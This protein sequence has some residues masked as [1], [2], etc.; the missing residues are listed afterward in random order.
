M[1]TVALCTTAKQWKQPKSP[2][3]NEWIKKTYLYTME[4]YSAKKNEK[5]SLAG[6]WT[7]LE[8]IMLSEVSQKQKA[9]GCMF[10]LICGIQTQYKH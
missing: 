8:N 3:T 5:L 2:T 10:S 7:E 6:K 4:F 9:K 1:F